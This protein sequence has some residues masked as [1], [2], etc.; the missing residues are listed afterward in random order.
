MLSRKLN[1]KSV[2]LLQNEEH[3]SSATDQ[4]NHGSNDADKAIEVLKAQGI[5]AYII[6]EAVKSDEGVIIC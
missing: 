4:N 3:S 6:G 2:L 5:D 1:E